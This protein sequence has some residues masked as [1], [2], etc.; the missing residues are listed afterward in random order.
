MATNPWHVRG[1]PA[2]G[3]NDVPAAMYRRLSPIYDRRAILMRRIAMFFPIV[4][5]I[6]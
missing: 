3:F 1:T 2:L 5:V 6:G 4:S